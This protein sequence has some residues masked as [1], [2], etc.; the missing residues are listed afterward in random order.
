MTLLTAVQGGSVPGGSGMIFEE[1]LNSL[2][3]KA[4]LSDQP[5]ELKAINDQFLSITKLFNLVDGLKRVLF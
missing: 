2:V 4:T 5:K 3:L 1:E